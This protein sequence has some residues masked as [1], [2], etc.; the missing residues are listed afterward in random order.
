M[1]STPAPL[2]VTPRNAV[3]T[4]SQYLAFELDTEA[5]RLRAFQRVG[6]Q[7]G[8]VSMEKIWPNGGPTPPSNATAEA[9]ERRHSGRRGQPLPAAVGS[10]RV[11]AA[12]PAVSDRSVVV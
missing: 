1:G 4:P 9:A 11:L 5:R 10:I 12:S 6:N 8:T 3:G 2:N 7:W